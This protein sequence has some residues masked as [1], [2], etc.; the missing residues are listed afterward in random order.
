VVSTP[1]LAIPQ[2]YLSSASLT[3]TSW[4][5]RFF[6]AAAP[7]KS[8]SGALVAVLLRGEHHFFADKAGYVGRSL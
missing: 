3:N 1:I 8:T 2:T 5:V 4:R 6:M 7:D